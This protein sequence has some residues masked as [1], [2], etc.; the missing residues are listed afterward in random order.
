VPC[1]DVPFDTNLS[2]LDKNSSAPWEF[3]DFSL[4]R[5][6]PK[7]HNFS[8][9]PDLRKFLRFQ[10]SRFEMVLKWNRRPHAV[11]LAALQVFFPRLFGPV[12]L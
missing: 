2:P 7:D 1:A 8:D 4:S 5:G 10:V 6:F 11:E 3:N 9:F 12:R